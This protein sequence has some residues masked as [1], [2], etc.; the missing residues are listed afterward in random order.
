MC[1]CVCVCVCVWGGG[2]AAVRQL[3]IDAGL[4]KALVPH[5]H[6]NNPEMLLNAGRAIGRIC[7]D[8]GET[9]NV[10]D[11][12]LMVWM[13]DGWLMGRPI[14]SSSAAGAAGPERCDPQAGVHHQGPPRER[15]PDQRLLAG[16][17]Q[18]CGSG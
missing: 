18:P 11:E 10:V 16:T 15:A 12:W 5:L 7:Y 6:S 8:N 2:V 1:V 3:C 17:L 9:M 4:V 14:F 13:D